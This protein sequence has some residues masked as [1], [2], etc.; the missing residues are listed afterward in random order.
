MKNSVYAQTQTKANYNEDK[1]ITAKHWKIYYYLLSVSK[2]DAD[3]VEDHRYVYKK[4]FNISQACRELGI[5]STQTFYNAI[6]RLEKHGLVKTSKNNY[7]LYA[8]NWIS[9]DKNILSNLVK[10]SKTREQDIDLL[11]TFLI[12]KK[13]N[14]I[15]ENTAD[16]S[17]TLRQLSVLLG[18][19]STH[20][21]YYENIRIY[22]ALLN[23]WGLIELKQHKQFNESL[24]T[25][26]TIFHLQRISETDLN[27]DFESDIKAEMNAPLPSEELMNKLK[28]VFPNIIND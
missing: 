18:H 15:A 19:G 9:V 23:F 11:R 21:Q 2:F 24:G 1:K 26:Y 13:M 17:F 27:A 8:K 12:L 14:K 10:Y 5:K 6:E 25:S 3:Q 20:P 7:F 22:L 16:K 4:D 28:F